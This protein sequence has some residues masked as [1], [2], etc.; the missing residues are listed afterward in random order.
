MI[1][2][3]I[4]TGYNNAM[5]EQTPYRSPIARAG[6]LSR[7]EENIENW[8]KKCKKNYIHNLQLTKKKICFVGKGVVVYVV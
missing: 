3:K 4:E 8:F 5:D 1:L 2:K 7:K 6:T